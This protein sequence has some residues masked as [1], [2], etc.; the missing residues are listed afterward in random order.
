[1]AKPGIGAATA[2]PGVEGRCAL[3]P[4][5]AAAAAL[6]IVLILVTA[7]AAQEVKSVRIGYPSLGFRQG[8]IWV[9]KDEG[10]FRKY[11]LDVEPVF[12]R[13]GQ[14]AI[15][16]LA[17]GDPP[18]MSIGQVVQANLSG[19]SLA[20]IAGVE[21]YY[22]STI[23]G[24]PGL[25]TPEQLKGKRLGISGYGAATHFAALI[26]A[27]HFNLDPNKDLTLVP[28]G[29][30]A[31][32]LAALTAGK[33]DASVFN[34][35]T[36]PITR[37]MGFHELVYL[38]DLR[39]EVQGNGLATT[40]SY[41]KSNRETVKAALRGYIEAIHFIFYDK[42][43]A[44]KA[45]AKYMRTTD[46]DVLEN[47]YQVYIATTPKR[48]YPT[49]KGLQ[50]LLDQLTPQMP[51]AKNAKPEQFVDLSFLQELEKEGFFSEMAKRYP[52]KKS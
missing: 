7:S 40:R 35:S 39:V 49:L 6:G 3:K 25:S 30:D 44:Q 43:A 45:F 2:M 36:V 32:R 26:V 9:G 23:F 15:Q 22:D 11:G 34:S 4:S 10:L 41:I 46:A 52:A 21:N 13:G 47:S 20:L 19:F 28:G 12:L 16:A 50:F 29:P 48:P 14:L 1:M 27:K 51:Q 24:R 8:H 42:Q 31:E 38:P 17:A 37:K 33:I 18:I 5:V